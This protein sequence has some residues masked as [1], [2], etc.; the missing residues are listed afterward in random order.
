MSTGRSYTLMGRRGDINQNGD[1]CPSDG[2]ASIDTNGC[3]QKFWKRT[4]PSFDPVTP[5]LKDLLE[6]M[7]ACLPTVEKHAVSQKMFVHFTQKFVH[8]LYWQY[9][10]SLDK[11]I[12][13]CHFCHNFVMSY[14][15]H[16]LTFFKFFRNW[17]I[18]S[19]YKIHRKQVA[20][21]NSK[22]LII[23]LQ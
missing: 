9:G 21:N 5:L 22:K 18:F 20:E 14:E 4:C 19:C 11:K 17:C 13:K 16:G 7:L 3:A 23:I 15:S 8:I 1:I 6:N 12:D 10:I 2:R